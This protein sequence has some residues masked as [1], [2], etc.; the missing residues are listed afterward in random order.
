M[1][2]KLLKYMSIRSNIAELVT[3]SMMTEREFSEDTTQTDI[4]DILYTRDNAFEPSET[5]NN[6]QKT[7]MY[8]SMQTSL[9]SVCG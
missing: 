7:I 3:V 4:L 1:V 5:L 2:I 9:Q 6:I 8:I